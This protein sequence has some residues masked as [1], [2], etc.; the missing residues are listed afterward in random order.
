[1]PRT[2]CGGDRDM[3][4]SVPLKTGHPGIRCYAAP[5]PNAPGLCGFCQG[6]RHGTGFDQS[7]AGV[8]RARAASKL[9]QAV[10]GHPLSCPSGRHMQHQPSRLII[11]NALVV[12]LDAEDRVF[13]S[14]DVL[15][16]DGAVGDVDDA[17]A[18][19]CDRIIEGA[20]LGQD[21]P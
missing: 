2:T 7:P 1:M 15:V 9:S 8:T 12:T 3:V 4:R 10:S 18:Q 21:P 20:G 5:L 6:E 17:A 13:E 19:A 16:E 11:R 14:G